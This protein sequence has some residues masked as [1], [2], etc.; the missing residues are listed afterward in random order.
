MQC[1]QGD[2]V[3]RAALLVRWWRTMSGQ[4]ICIA[5][6]SSRPEELAKLCRALDIT[7]FQQHVERCYQAALQRDVQGRA[8][9]MFRQ[10]TILAC[11]DAALLGM[12]WGYLATP[13]TSIIRT[14][15]HPDYASPGCCTDEVHQLAGGGRGW[16]C[17]GN[18]LEYID[19]GKTKLR[20]VF[21]HHKTSYRGACRQVSGVHWHSALCVCVCVCVCVHAQGLT[22]AWPTLIHAAVQ[23]QLP[24]PCSRCPSIEV[25]MLGVV[26]THTSLLHGSMS[27]QAWVLNCASCSVHAPSESKRTTC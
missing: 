24:T 8:G 14:M 11:R 23:C 16:D 27:G 4:C 2:A 15:R 21:A 18:R 19:P 13:R 9:R 12:Q 5:E 26:R 6:K 7:V 20:A 10:D 22:L 1:L 17:A 25:L 3:I